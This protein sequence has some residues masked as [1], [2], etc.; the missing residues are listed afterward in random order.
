MGDRASGAEL[1]YTALA[2]SQ[3][4]A[5]PQLHWDTGFWGRS[6]HNFGSAMA[7]C[8][9]QSVC[10]IG[11]HIS[12][13][14]TY[15]DDGCR[16]PKLP[17]SSGS[18]ETKADT[19]CQNSTSPMLVTASCS[20]QDALLC[21]YPGDTVCLKLSH[22]PSASSLPRGT[23]SACYCFTRA[24]IV[25]PR[26]SPFFPQPSPSSFL[27]GA[28]LL[29]RMGF[30]MSTGPEHPSPSWCS[31][32]GT[33]LLNSGP[34]PPS[35]IPGPMVAL[36]VGGS[37]VV[38]AVEHQVLLFPAPGLSPLLCAPFLHVMVLLFQVHSLSCW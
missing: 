28:T 4:L 17:L 19:I 7:P 10:S 16:S 30:S 34:F 36:P 27:L 2:Q 24:F 14:F 13:H 25:L 1:Q 21:T 32:V 15:R 31:G 12:W 35:T 20:C 5:P 37:F 38:T 18:S 9:T 26:N 23:V 29:L 33:T 22:V 6:C 11:V 3:H 8:W